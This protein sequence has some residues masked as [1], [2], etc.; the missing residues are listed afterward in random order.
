MC[1]IKRVE[2]L[3]AHVLV[4]TRMHAQGVKQSVRLVVGTKIARSRVLGICACCKHSK[5]VDTYEKLVYVRFKFA[6][7]GSLVLQIV[8]FPFTMPV[9]YRLHPLRWHVHVLMRA[10]L[11]SMQVRVTKS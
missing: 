9:V 2:H 10:C 11:T 3:A 8:H 7:H 6:G 4:V 5:S 1:Y